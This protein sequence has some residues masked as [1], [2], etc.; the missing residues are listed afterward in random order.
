MKKPI[1]WIVA[2]V[3]CLILIGSI[4]LVNYF[5]KVNNYQHA[6][7]N[8]EYQNIDAASIPD[9]TYLGECNVE[10]IYAKVSVTVKKE[11]I[12]EIDLLEHRHDR[13]IEAESI[14]QQILEQQRIDVDAVTG[15]TNSSTV[16]K[17][18]IDNAL[19]SAHAAQLQ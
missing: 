13:G 9:G 1:K 5:I 12:T 16:L 4:P 2:V 17:K 18:A 15:A 8:I 3:G 14:L 19:S 11:Q 6:V 10:F 7:A